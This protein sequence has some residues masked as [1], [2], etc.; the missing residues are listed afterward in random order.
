LRVEAT[1]IAPAR[2]AKTVAPVEPLAPSVEPP[3]ELADP[4]LEPPPEPAGERP[5]EPE[6]AAEPPPAQEFSG[7]PPPPRGRLEFGP[8]FLLGIRGPFALHFGE[9]EDGVSLHRYAPFTA[10][11]VLETGYRV[12]SVLTV[13]LTGSFF[14]GSASSSNDECPTG[15]K[16][17]AILAGVGADLILTPLHDERL[18]IGLGGQWSYMVARRET[19]STSTSP[20]QIDTDRRYTAVGPQLSIGT[21]FA[22]SYVP[23]IQYGVMIAYSMRFGLSASGKNLVN[24]VAQPGGDAGI[25]HTI[26]FLGRFHFDL[27]VT[28]HD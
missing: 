23:Q 27:G 16:C 19:E 26:L 9:L 14:A 20:D 7:G 10:G 4:P 12:D 21:D 5:A 25:T 18:W 15:V 22:D 17:R 8:G 28:R 3:T 2:A 1:P 13:A 11:I 6:V 24:D